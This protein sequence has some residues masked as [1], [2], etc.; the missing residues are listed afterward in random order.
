VHVIASAITEQEFPIVKRGYDPD[1]VAA[2][3]DEVA[4]A[5][6]S[7]EEHARSDAM[8]LAALERRAQGAREAEQ[9]VGATLIAASDAK[10]RII[11]AAENR[12]REIIAAAERRAAGIAGD[13]PARDAAGDMGARLQAAEDEAASLV[14]KAAETRR[15]AVREAEETVAAARA[16]ALRVLEATK[17]QA[18]EVIARAGEERERVVEGLRG[19]H[20]ALLATLEHGGNLARE[21]D[22]ALSFPLTVPRPGVVVLE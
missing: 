16:E 14:R 19:L 6:R 21:L 9:D 5:Y 3:L 18:E 22:A 20:D 13:A 4:A 2:F 7:L 10:A 1:A 15:L 8:R 17:A 11:A 12:A